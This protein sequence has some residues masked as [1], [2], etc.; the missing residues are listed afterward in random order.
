MTTIYGIPNCDT[1]RKARKWLDEHSVEHEFHDIRV[2][3]LEIQ[4]I[5][6]WAKHVG[7]EKLLNTRSQTWRKIAQ[8]NRESIDEGRALALMFEQPTLIKRP[9]LECGK[10]ILVG[11]SEDDYAKTVGC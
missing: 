7:W 4:A 10:E 6:R 2:D 9:V 1:C 11:F 5:H 3:G 8:A